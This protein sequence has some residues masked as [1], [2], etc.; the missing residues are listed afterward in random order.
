MWLY[1]CMI[2]LFLD[3]IS[4]L[5]VKSFIFRLYLVFFEKCYLKPRRLPLFHL[6][7]YFKPWCEHRILRYIYGILC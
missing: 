7:R 3:Y 6:A 1:V 4:N 5:L 2:Q